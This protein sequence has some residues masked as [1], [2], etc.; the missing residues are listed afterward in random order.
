MEVFLRTFFS[1]LAWIVAVW[2]LGVTVMR[3]IDSAEDVWVAFP[4]GLL[5]GV[6]SWPA[7]LGVMGLI[8]AAT[9]VCQSARKRQ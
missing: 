2:L 5:V 7:S 3:G 1:F 8:F 9:F 6:I 4:V